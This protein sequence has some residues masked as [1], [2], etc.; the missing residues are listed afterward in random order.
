MTALETE[1]IK[2]AGGDFTALLL[3]LF[4]L[5]A[6]SIVVLLLKF[7]LDKLPA[8]IKADRD[9]MCEQ[10]KIHNEQS[11]KQIEA[12][13]KQI[14]SLISAFNEFVKSFSEKIDRQQNIYVD[15]LK[16]H[17]DQAKKILET[18]QNIKIILEQRPCIKQ[19]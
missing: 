15:K 16:E 4:A 12:S 11:T 19:N 1:L 17:D 13:N 14:S 10:M 3:I 18:D 9:A 6:C 5:L 7:V 2:S 8:E